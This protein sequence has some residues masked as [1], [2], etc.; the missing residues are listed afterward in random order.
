M[1]DHGQLAVARAAAVNIAVASPHWPCPGSKIGTCDIDQRLAK[2]GAARLIA[3]EGR[4]D[5]AFLQ[6]DSASDAD[7]FLAFADVNAAGDPTAAIHTG[8]FFFKR[9]RQQHPA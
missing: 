7:C 2:G 4:E 1:T 6:K 8:K 5:V 3:N 9:S